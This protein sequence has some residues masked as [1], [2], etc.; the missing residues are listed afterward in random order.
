LHVALLAS[1]IF[2]QTAGLHGLGESE[3]RLLRYAGILH[4]IG[5]HIGYHKHHKHGYYLIINSG[6][7]GLAIED[8]DIIAQLVRY[9]RR[10]T[11]KAS[12]AQFRALPGKSR[13][14]VKW[15]SAILRI[16]DSLD[17]S[18]FSLVRGIRCRLTGRRVCFELLTDA[19]RAEIDLDLSSAKQNAA[20]FEKVFDVETSFA[21]GPSEPKK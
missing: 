6:L 2:E 11:P 20:Y 21:A 3:G 7:P 17:R 15:L 9:H 1:Q 19:A 8:R 10:A 16:A 18:H 12:H 14:L 13:K 4:D 5:Y